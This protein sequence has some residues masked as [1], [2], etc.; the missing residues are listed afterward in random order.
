MS[1]RDLMIKPEYRNGMDNM[2][3]DFYLPILEKST[4]YCRA[5]GFFS[6]TS[7]AKISKGLSA[8][9][10]NGGKMQLVASP[11]LSDDDV[12]AIKKGYADKRELIEKKLLAELQEPKNHFEKKRLNL[13]AHL[14]AT[15]QLEIKIAMIE[16]NN[17]GIFHEKMGL[18]YDAEGN[19]IAFTGSMNES[20]MAFNKN[21]ESIDVYCSWANES[22][23]SRV[24][25]KENA[26]N[27]VWNNTE[28][29]IEVM[30]FPKVSEE[31]LKRYKR[32]DMD[33]SHGDYDEV[34]D[35]DEGI[36]NSEIIT[37]SLPKNR[38]TM[39]KWLKL[40]D[41]QQEALAEWEN[42]GFRGIFD[43]AT[44]TGKTLTGLGAV[45]RLSD[46]L[47]GKLGVVIVCPYQHLVEQWVE[48]IRE[49]SVDPL[50]CYSSY[51][52]KKAMKNIVEDFKYDVIDNFCIIT[53]NATLATPDFQKY[54]DKLK[55]NICLVVDEAHNFG[56]TRQL[57]CMKEVYKYRL[58]LSAT[59]ERHHDEEGTEALKTYFG[60]KCVEYSLDRAIQ[61]GFLT[62]YYY[63][64]IPIYFEPDE[65]EEYNELSEKIQKCM[66]MHT[67]GEKLPKIVE[68]LLI[69]RAR[70]VAKARNK[71]MALYEIIYE[72][73]KTDNQMLIYCGA[74]SYLE[75]TEDGEDLEVKRQ[76]DKVVGKL[77]KEF[78]MK[79]SKFTSEEDSEEREMLIDH[80]KNGSMLQALV[81]IKCLD[82]GVNIPS[83]RT[84]FILASSTNPKEYVQR[85]GRVLRTFK[86][87]T[88]AVIYDFIT[89]PRSLDERIRKS[90]ILDSEMSLVR[91]EFDRM[92]EFARLS[93]NP[94]DVVSL[95]DRIAEF[96]NL[97]YQG[98]KDYGS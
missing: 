98:G 46:N 53:T 18:M 62:P 93:E 40:H 32:E 67:K 82:E 77:G 17:I 36:E 58:A 87:K 65:L 16:N 75:E 61:E 69:K 30:D 10:Q 1:F 57:E 79:V 83:I 66:R 38:F 92:V 20:D 47:N 29:K 52:W 51:N 76:I 49:F 50:I 78:G 71:L 9:N 3:N 96:Y 11:A 44:G 5:V 39:P 63:Y 28:P 7:L 54:I 88:H 74:T 34:D 94:L 37:P 2:V 31:I 80:F 25:N 64:P 72:K 56:A 6:S 86:N 4:R 23:N 59:L 12:E 45:T 19:V 14:I 21:Y 81:A 24:A 85:R 22:D 89:L 15:G 26:F 33:F 97:N 43:M 8:L 68:Q 60:E 84:A 27:S 48:D 55:G 73:Y 90:Q 70:V 91:R 95:Q 13:L 35:Y 41:Y 42:N